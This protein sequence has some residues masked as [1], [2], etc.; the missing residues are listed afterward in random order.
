MYSLQRRVRVLREQ[1]QRRDL[2]LELLRRKLALLEDGAR[3]KCIVQNERDE[4]VNRA[5]RS[6]KHAERTGQQLIEAKAQL[7]ELKSQLADAADYKVSPSSVSFFR[8]KLL[9]TKIRSLLWNV[10]VR[11][12]NFK[13]VLE[14]SKERN[15]IC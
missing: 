9:I 11:S 5:R 12:K 4:A 2:H 6:T 15:Q 13:L 7:S 1:V 3:G 14:T 10:P 8:I